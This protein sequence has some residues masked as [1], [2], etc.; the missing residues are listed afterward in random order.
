MRGNST[1]R[2]SGSNL[3]KQVGGGIA[4]E[5]AG[6]TRRSLYPTANAGTSKASQAF[7]QVDDIEREV[8]ELK[9]RGVTFEEYDTPGTKTQ[10][11]IATGGGAKAAWFKDTRR[12]YPR[13][14]PERPKLAER[15]SRAQCAFAARFGPIRKT[16]DPSAALTSGAGRD[17]CF[18]DQLRVKLGRKQSSVHTVAAWATFYRAKRARSTWRI[19]PIHDAGRGQEAMSSLFTA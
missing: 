7:W 10:N 14:D 19:A 2:S 1:R 18:P 15:I 3:A 16:L 11:G 5:F 4:Y 12:Q 8:A 17:Q 9:S 13:S 6:G